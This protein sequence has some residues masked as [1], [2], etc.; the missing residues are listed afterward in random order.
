MALVNITKI[1]KV[2]QY[3]TLENGIGFLLS[4]E[5][6]GAAIA[7]NDIYMGIVKD[8]ET[9]EELIVIGKLESDEEGQTTG[10]GIIITQDGKV[11][12]K[13]KSLKISKPEFTSHEEASSALEKGEEYYL[14]GDRNVYRK[15]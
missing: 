15:P 7:G 10:F 6:G 12:I 11:G 8:S 5:I 4:P 3:E 9:E 13:G 2:S 14:V 1:T